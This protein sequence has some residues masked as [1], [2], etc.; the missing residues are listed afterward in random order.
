MRQVDLLAAEFLKTKRSAGKRFAIA[1]PLCLAGLAIVQQG[2]FSLNLFNWFYVVFLPVT[3]AVLSAAIVNLDYAKH[4]L[5]TL[6]SLPIS[7]AQ[8]WLTKCLVAASYAWL[9]CLLLGIA[10]FLIPQLLAL[11]GIQQLQPLSI[12][13]VLTGMAVMFCTT[14]WQIPCCFLLNY[15]LGIVFT[16]VVNGMLSITGVLLATTSAWILYPW[17][18]VSH[19]MI[20]AIGVL[21]NGLPVDGHVYT[22]SA[23]LTIACSAALLLTVVLTYLTIRLYAHT[24]AH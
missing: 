12:L 11:L 1:S 21:P 6:R 20:D 15:K 14:I 10:V 24:E 23:D 8:L 22:H 18:W 2:Y 9:S 17:A 16:V 19:S 5:R 13:T 4:G 7:Q 3:F